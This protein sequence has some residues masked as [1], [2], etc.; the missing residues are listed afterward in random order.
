MKTCNIILTP[1][2]KE[3]CHALATT[4]A[5]N[6]KLCLKVINKFCSKGRIQSMKSAHAEPVTAGLPCLL[7]K[8]FLSMCKFPRSSKFGPRQCGCQL[9]GDV[10]SANSWPSKMLAAFYFFSKLGYSF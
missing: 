6:L 2:T 5:F 7:S 1:T 8:P 10:V 4:S 3:P 9:S